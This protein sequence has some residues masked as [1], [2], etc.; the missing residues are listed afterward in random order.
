[1]DTLE[2]ELTPAQGLQKIAEVIGRT[3][4]NIKEQ[5]FCFLLWGWLIAIASFSYFILNT[6]TSFKLF[7]LPFPI[8]V[9]I[10]IIATVYYYQ[11][12][13]YD[14]ETYLSH[15]LK[16][17]WLVLGLSFI[18]VVFINIVEQYTPF[19][20]TLLIGGIGTLVSGLMLRFKPLILGG[21]IFLLFSVV[22]IFVTDSIK[23]LLQ[24]I[25]VLTG[26]LIPGY[27]L[28]YSKS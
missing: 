12:R 24:G 10:G 19:T 6:Y 27:L 1:M 18:L 23:P 16:I 15:Y 20:Y 9:I 25:A 28:K 11:G 17:L 22:S 5:G 7:Y 13:R 8:L 26:Y 14:A 21:C 4:E 2:N 3:K